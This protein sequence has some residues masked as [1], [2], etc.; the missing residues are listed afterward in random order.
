MSAGVTLRRRRARFEI[1][2]TDSQNLAVIDLGHRI[3]TDLR[4]ELDRRV[5]DIGKPFKS[6]GP[7]GTAC[8]PV[9]GAG[10]GIASSLAAGNVFFAT[11]NPAT[12]MPLGSGVG[13]AVMAATGGGIVSQAPFVA[14][15]SALMPVVMPVLLFTAFSSMMMSVRFD[16]I[17]QTL[18]GMA[19]LMQQLLKR[20]MLEDMARFLSTIERLQDIHEEYRNGPGFTDEMKIRLALVERDANV[21]RH[22]HYALATGTVQTVDAAKLSE[23][24]KKLF[25]ASS[26]A[27]LQVDQ[28]RLLLALQDNPADATRSSS[29]LED[30]VK[31]Y[32][33][34]YR[35][36]AENSPTKAFKDA[37]KKTINE[38]KWLDRHL[39]KKKEAKN[40][41]A[42]IKE[43][44]ERTGSDLS[45]ED[46][47]AIRELVA[48]PAEHYSLL[49]WRDN[50]G[51]GRL[52]AWYTEDY[53][54]ELTRGGA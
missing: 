31:R 6:G 46:T 17:E 53:K 9:V 47:G 43:L 10:S 5:L 24:D 12:L 34:D 20:E 51:T 2:E 8:L 38:M 26:I 21:L 22:K 27:D 45:E 33:A 14:A 4:K 19:E 37:L 23:V 41:Q 42:T 28:L 54:L 29:A 35:S 40:A 36:L 32:R 25:V 3:G 11:A 49:F 52:R 13:S 1:V 44:D 39:L 30:K 50:N 16:R 18:V 15:G 7:L 48:D